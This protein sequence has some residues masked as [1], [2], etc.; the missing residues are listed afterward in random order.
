MESVY[1]L[2]RRTLPDGFY[3]VG[4]LLSATQGMIHPNRFDS[5]GILSDETEKCMEILT[6]IKRK[7]LACTGMR[8]VN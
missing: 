7:V 4:V 6:L 1:I 2:G 8:S 5:Q 3:W